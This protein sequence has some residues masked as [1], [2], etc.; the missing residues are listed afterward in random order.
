[1]KKKRA[2]KFLLISAALVVVAFICMN[3]NWSNQL[4]RAI[5]N[6]NIT[7]FENMMEE[8]YCFSVNMPAGAPWGL[9][10]TSEFAVKT[11][12]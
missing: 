1:M 2:I 7:D 10:F 6:E 5:E 12:L 3:Y 4:I 8:K 11:P 9:Q